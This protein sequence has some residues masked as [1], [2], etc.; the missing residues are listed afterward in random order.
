MTLDHQAPSADDDAEL[1]PEC[2]FSARTSDL[3]AQ[4]HD[5]PTREFYLTHKK[6]FKGHVEEPFQQLFRQ[7]ATQ[8]PAQIKERMKTES[9]GFARILKNDWGRGSAWDFYWGAFYPEGGKRHDPEWEEIAP[10]VPVL[11]PRAKK[12]LFSGH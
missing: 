10:S 6:E 9:G 3:L 7:V 5:K 12:M 11:F 2:P 1:H 4:L 8:L